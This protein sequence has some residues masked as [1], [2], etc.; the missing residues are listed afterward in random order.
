[1]LPPC[2]ADEV[3][4]LL[5]ELADV[6]HDAHTAGVLLTLS[7]ELTEADTEQDVARKLVDSVPELLPT[8]VAAVMLWDEVAHSARLGAALGV[9]A[10]VLEVAGDVEVTADDAPELRQ[11]VDHGETVEI[12]VATASPVVAAMLQV[13]GL[14]RLLLVPM[15]AR[16]RLQGFV[17]AAAEELTLRDGGNLRGIADQGAIALAHLRMID[18]FRYQALHDPLTGLANR[19][20]LFDRLE[21]AL[22]HSARTERVT[23]VMFVDLDDFKSINDNLGHLVGDAALRAV[24]HRLEMEVRGSDTVARFGDDAFVLVL[25]NIEQETDVD[26]VLGHVLTALSTP[27]DIGGRLVSLSASVGVAIGRD[28]SDPEGVLTLADDAMQVVKERKQLEG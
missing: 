26:V 8:H 3:A 20:L 6:R 28:A 17:I 4:A 2:P 7:R 12:D 22:H 11:L 14:S 13:V 21:Q 18:Q 25:T 5:K 10:A 15:V 1:M 16:Q 9:T 19:T 23:A 24:A 27:F